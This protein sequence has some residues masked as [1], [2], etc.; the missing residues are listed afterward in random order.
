LAWCGTIAH[1]E[2]AANVILFIDGAILM[3]FFIAGLF[4]LKFWRRTH[5]RLFLLFA[6]SFWIMA[7]NRLFLSFYFA[8]GEHITIIYVIRLLAFVV[9]L[10]A[11]LDKN[12]SAGKSTQASP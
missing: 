9:I 11:I 2:K 10:C 6:I 8:Q 3:A 5:D 7:I 4:F 12:R 1:D